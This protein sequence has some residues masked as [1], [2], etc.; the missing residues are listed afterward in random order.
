MQLALEPILLDFK[1]LQEIRAAQRH[2]NTS[3]ALHVKARETLDAFAKA[4][5]HG[6]KYLNDLFSWKAYL[7][8]HDKG[9]VKASKAPS[10]TNY[11]T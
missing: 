1:E 9:S 4:P 6:P 2:D 5:Y 3:H 10:S 8:L 11:N 7:A